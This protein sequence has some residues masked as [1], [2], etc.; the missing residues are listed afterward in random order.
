MLLSEEQSCEGWMKTYRIH[1]INM[2]YLKNILRDELGR[3]ITEIFKNKR[4]LPHWGGDPQAIGQHLAVPM[5]MMLMMII[6]IWI[7]GM[8][9]SCINSSCYN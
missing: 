1:F 2:I 7:S 5:M 9:M 3:M 8:R 6:N 4:C